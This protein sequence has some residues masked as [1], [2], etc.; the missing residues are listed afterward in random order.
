MLIKLK[1]G[2]SIC[3]YRRAHRSVSYS[4]EMRKNL[5]NI[6]EMEEAEIARYFVLI[7]HVEL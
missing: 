3:A 4:K 5:T 1:K 7:G 2:R 6:W